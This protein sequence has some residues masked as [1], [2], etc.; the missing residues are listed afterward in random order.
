M[1]RVKG[2]TAFITGAASGLGEASTLLLAKEGAAIVVADI[3]ESKG[4]EVVKKIQQEGGKALFVKLDVSNETDWENA[5]VKTLSEFQKLDIL[6]NNAGIQYVKELEDTPL[7]DWRKLMSICLDGVFLGTKHAIRAMKETGGGSIINI[8]SVVGI[9]GTVDSTSA[10]CAAKGGVRAFT[11]AA[12]LECSKAGRNYNIRVNSIHPGATETQMVTEML[13]DKTI[14]ETLE[15][16]H[17]IGNLGKPI[18]IA[19]GVLYLA[20]DESRMVT[21]AEMVIDGG[22]T[23]W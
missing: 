10:Y 12:A 20:S 19:Y 15:K 8:S 3:N 22:W 4:Q 11:K 1:D 21:G 18:D 7:E 9:V 13:K 23:A 16:A 17:P 6:V 2:K 14:R 5:I